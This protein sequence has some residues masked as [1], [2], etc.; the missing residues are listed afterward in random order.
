LVIDIDKYTALTNKQANFTIHGTSPTETSTLYVTRNSDINDLSTEKIITVIYQYDYEE[1]DTRGNVTPISERHI[2]NIHLQFKSGIPIV[3]DIKAPEIVLPGDNVSLRE[4][5]VTPGAYEVTGGGWEMFENI[6]DAESHT[7]GI[8]YSPNFD[9]LYWYQDGYLVAY[10]AK[11]YLGKTYSNTVKLGV[12]NYH[13]LKRVM[14]DKLN[15]YYIDNEQVKREPKIYINDYS[16]AGQNG[17]KLFSDLIDLTH[18]KPLDGHTPLQ[19][20]AADATK[21]PMRG[22]KYLEFFLRANQSA[23]AA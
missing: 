16:A 5:N 10:Y 17:L 21:K 7:N 20:T 4:P 9:P 12:A 6:D 22:G 23:P 2:V 1:T 14:D 11:T 15:H 18:G 13:D 8:E 3:E 19:R